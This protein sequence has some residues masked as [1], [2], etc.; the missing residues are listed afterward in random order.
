MQERRRACIYR[1]GHP[2]FDTLGGGDT[3]QWAQVRRFVG[4]VADAEGAYPRDKLFC[5]ARENRAMD[6]DALDRDTYLPSIGEA[7]DHAARERVIEVGILVDDH[8]GISTQLQNRAL[9]VRQ[10]LQFPTDRIGAGE[11]EDRQTRFDRQ[12]C[13]DRLRRL[14]RQD[15]ER[16]AGPVGSIDDLG[17]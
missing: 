16:A 15:R 12:Q 7:A 6:E 10:F 1:L 8:G 13:A 2:A 9:A 3:D 5:P 17:E 11:G 14:G 4:G